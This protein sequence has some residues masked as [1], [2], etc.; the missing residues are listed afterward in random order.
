MSDIAFAAA[1]CKLA[2]AIFKQ[3]NRAFDLA[4]VDWDELDQT[5]RHLY[6]GQAGDILHANAPVCAVP[7]PTPLFDAFVAQTRR[8]FQVI[9]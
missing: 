7:A 3:R 4:C 5:T 9:K 8:E 2:K 1:A 6:V